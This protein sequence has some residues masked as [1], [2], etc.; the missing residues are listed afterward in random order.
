MTK[1]FWIMAIV[2]VVIALGQFV[3]ALDSSQSAPQQ[4]AS[5]GLALCFA[6]I[7]YCLARAVS[8]IARDWAGSP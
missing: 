2:G 6:I 1:F 8:E 4:A 3:L 7:P 5:A